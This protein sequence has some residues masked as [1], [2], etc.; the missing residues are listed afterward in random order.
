MRSVKVTV[1][2]KG[3]H[4]IKRRLASGET[5]LY[6][7]AWRGGPA[8][9]CSD[10]RSPKFAAELEWHR[11]QASG[12][13]PLMFAD[14]IDQ[15]TGPG[16]E[17][18]PDFLLLAETTRRDHLYAF[19]LAKE[20]WPQLPAALTQQKGFKAEV[21]RWHRSF[22]ANPRKADKL[23]FSLSK[24]FSYAVENELLEKNPCTGIGRL[25]SGSR[26][27]TVW[28]PD[29]I[30]RFRSEAAPHILLPFEMAI[31]TGQRQGDILAAA[32]NQY[33]GTH[34]R[35]RQSKT[36]AKVKVRVSN[37]LRAMLDPL[38]RDALRICL[39]SRGRPWTKDGFKTTWG[40]ELARLGIEG[41]TFHDLRGTFITARVSEGSSLEDVARVTGHSVS[42]VRAV[43]EKHYL[44]WDQDA[45][46][47]VI[48]RM[49]KNA[50]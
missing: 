31:A 14:L 15:F 25:Y 8:M 43:A 48:L 39:N 5:K 38:P 42:E 36:G 6:F 47:R 23:L 20:Q 21:R 34:L 11:A 22:A 4:R 44:A 18:N 49:D 45:A 27:E 33:D 12:K 19:R 2:M 37:T 28:T 16:R 41:V 24:V 9:S 30:D 50:K 29:L 10:P 1:D 35:V 3:V 17:P 40:K 13:R 26:K 32:W 7:Y 46:D